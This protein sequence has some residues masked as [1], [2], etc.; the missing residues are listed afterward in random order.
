MP[1]LGPDAGVARKTAGDRQHMR[2]GKVP[3]FPHYQHAV[4]PQMA[5]R[6][7]RQGRVVWEGEGEDE[8]CY[9]LPVAGGHDQVN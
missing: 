5:S 8:V 9:I 4:V 1:L 3:G 6:C 7:G 2:I